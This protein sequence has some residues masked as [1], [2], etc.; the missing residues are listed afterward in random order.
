MKP[1]KW[2]WIPRKSE[3]VRFPRVWLY[4][5]WVLQ[6]PCRPEYYLLDHTFSSLQNP[7]F[8]K[9]KR[10]CC[11][12]HK[13]FIQSL[14]RK[15]FYFQELGKNLSA[16]TITYFFPFVFLV[17]LPP[18]INLM[19]AY[20]WLDWNWE[21]MQTLLGADCGS[22]VERKTTHEASLRTFSFPWSGI[23]LPIWPHFSHSFW[24]CS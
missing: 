12:W 9:D 20:I 17:F 5:P 3:N 1:R 23:Q 7:L 15:T 16:S 19:S 18:F 14:S 21:I 24:F 10:F 4:K 11:W 6:L 2:P 13:L 22:C 8:C